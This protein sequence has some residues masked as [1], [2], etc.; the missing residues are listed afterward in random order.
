M[1]TSIGRVK[2]TKYWTSW[3]TVPTAV[4]TYA[5]YSYPVHEFCSYSDRLSVIQPKAQHYNTPLNTF[6]ANLVIVP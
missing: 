2:I 6:G 3:N 5:G 1:K 4:A